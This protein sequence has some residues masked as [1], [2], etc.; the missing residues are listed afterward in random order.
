MASSEMD[1]SLRSSVEMG[2]ASIML[3]SG[4]AMLR[5]FA[6]T[7]DDASIRMCLYPSWIAFS[8]CPASDPQ[9]I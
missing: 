7:S 5:N 8:A 1:V 4:P 9:S 2:V 3:L 6:K